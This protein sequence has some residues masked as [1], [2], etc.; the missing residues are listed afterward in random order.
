M[1][2]TI[3]LRVQSLRAAACK[4]VVQIGTPC[5]PDPIMRQPCADR[6]EKRVTHRSDTIPIARDQEQLDL[7]NPN[8][9]GLLGVALTVSMFMPPHSRWRER[10]AAG[11]DVR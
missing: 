2:K 3:S 4:V 5:P 6:E 1:G 7:N 11:A 8:Q 9:R 10:P